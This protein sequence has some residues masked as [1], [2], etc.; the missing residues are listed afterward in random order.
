[1][2]DQERRFDF[3]DTLTI[4]AG[5]DGNR[6]TIHTNFITASSSQVLKAALSHGLQHGLNIAIPIVGD[7]TLKSYSGADV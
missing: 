3:T 4:S 1:M 7:S 6:H 5:E 2:T